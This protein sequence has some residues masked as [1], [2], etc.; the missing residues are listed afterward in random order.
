MGAQMG[1]VE[2]F[3]DAK[4]REL[5][6]YVAKRGQA[7]RHWNLTKLYK[8]L[9]LCD[10]QAYE[11]L[12]R[13]ITSAN[14]LAHEL[15]PVPEQR[16]VIFQAMVPSGEIVDQVSAGQR[17]RFIP[18]REPDLSGFSPQEIDI[19]NSAVEVLEPDSAHTANERSQM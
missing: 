3:N 16:G 9:F 19:I 4:F 12:G 10:F 14:Y 18:L 2:G 11:K 6:L 1:T 5:V 15:G 13:P 7:F 8:I 17:H